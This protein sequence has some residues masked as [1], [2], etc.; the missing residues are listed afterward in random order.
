MKIYVQESLLKGNY[1]YLRDVKQRVKQEFIKKVEEMSADDM[2]SIEERENSFII[3]I[4]I[5]FK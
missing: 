4:D 5:N 1:K 2:I 3:T